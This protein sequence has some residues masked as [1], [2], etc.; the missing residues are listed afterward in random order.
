MGFGGDEYTVGTGERLHTHFE[1]YLRDKETTF[2]R[3]AAAEE[4]VPFIKDFIGGQV[5]RCVTDKGSRPTRCS[6]R[7]VLYDAPF[8]PLRKR[9][10]PEAHRKAICP[11][12][13]TDGP[14]ASNEIRRFQQG[15]SADPKSARKF[16]VVWISAGAFRAADLCRWTDPQSGGC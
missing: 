7:Y 3:K 15:A 10:R 11:R 6:A 5:E 13:N 8:H 9:T 1:T 16:L 12:C 2:R 4:A 14:D